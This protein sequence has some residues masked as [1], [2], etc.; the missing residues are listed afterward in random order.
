LLPVVYRNPTAPNPPLETNQCW[1]SNPPK[2]PKCK[3][4]AYQ[5]FQVRLE[6]V[7]DSHYFASKI[8][9]TVFG[10]TPTSQF[11]QPILPAHTWHTMSPSKHL[12]IGAVVSFQSKFIHPHSL[13]DEHIPDRPSGH[14]LANAI[15]VSRQAKMINQKNTQCVIVHHEDFVD[16][17]GKYQDLWC[18]ESHIKVHREG[19][20]D[21]FFDDSK[22]M[23]VTRK[24][25]EDDSDDI[26]TQKHTTNPKNLRHHDGKRKSIDPHGFDD[27]LRPREGRDLMWRHINMTL[28]GN[29]KKSNEPNKKILDNVW[30]DVPSKQVTAIMGPSGSGKTSLLNILAGRAASNGRINIT[31]DI[32]LNNY[33]VDPTRI[34]VRNKIAFVAQDDSLQVTATPREA[35]RFSAKMRLPKTMTDEA[36]DNLT[37]T[38]LEEL[39][40][41]SCADVLVGGALLKG[42]SGGERKRTSVGVELVTH[43]ALVFLD[44]VREW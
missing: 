6:L 40:L 39:G 3:H 4:G 9:H 14:R 7:W 34:E 23:S 16:D 25:Y 42:I 30:G 10:D 26:E 19:E 38:M 32:R 27:P 41:M 15:V 11:S 5:V 29:K 33:T 24:D 13:R 22:S 21:K 17:E 20:P 8:W 18:A 2:S 1:H 12:G 44:E 43:P 31:A 28:I 37:E 35:I 36:L